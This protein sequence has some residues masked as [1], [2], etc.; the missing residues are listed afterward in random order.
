MF[1][2]RDEFDPI[3]NGINLYGPNDIHW[4]GYLKIGALIICLRYSKITHKW[5][6]NIEWFGQRAKQNSVDFFINFACNTSHIELSRN[7]I[8][9][10]RKIESSVR[11]RVNYCALQSLCSN[12]NRRMFR[13]LHQSVM[14]TVSDTWE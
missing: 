4:G 7:R 3:Q 6:A 9:L 8:K 10:D 1:Y 2:Y 5:H 11:D 14:L 12:R 13:Q